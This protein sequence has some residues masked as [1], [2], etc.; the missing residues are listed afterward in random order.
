M[1]CSDNS[2]PPK[3]NENVNTAKEYGRS[4]PTLQRIAQLESELNE[5]M[6][7]KGTTTTPS[8]QDTNLS[9]NDNNKVIPK[10]HSAIEN[11]IHDLMAVND[12]E[13]RPAMTSSRV[14]LKKSAKKSAVV[15]AN[16]PNAIANAVA[17]PSLS[18]ELNQRSR[19]IKRAASSRSTR[20]NSHASIGVET[21]NIFDILSSDDDDDIASS[22]KVMIKEVNGQ[23]VRLET[24]PETNREKNKAVTPKTTR[25]AVKKFL[26]QP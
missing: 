23:L 9:D 4:V 1:D 17:G 11:N 19:I 10:P 25:K 8:E 18:A 3:G 16:S 22:S 5:L 24:L 7:D 21:Q 26:C 15:V 14:F 12:Q 2:E 13:Y 6:K 20:S